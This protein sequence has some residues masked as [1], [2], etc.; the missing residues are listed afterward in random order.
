MCRTKSWCKWLS[1]Q[2]SPV[3]NYVCY[4]TLPHPSH[5]APLPSHLRLSLLAA[6]QRHLPRQNTPR[7][8]MRSQIHD[9][10][11]LD[12]VLEHCHLFPY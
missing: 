12:N 11:M 1:A 3:W 4:V 10:R 6:L 7:R 9:Q 2:L 8:F 5:S